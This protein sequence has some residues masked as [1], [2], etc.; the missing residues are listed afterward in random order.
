[1]R[2]LSEYLEVLVSLIAISVPFAV[3][4][5]FLSLTSNFDPKR[6]RQNAN[7]AALTVFITGVVAIYVGE[8][9]FHL[10][11]IGIPSFEVAGGLLI[12]LTGLAMVRDGPGTTKGEAS[13]H[14]VGVVPIGIPLLCGP[15]LISTI[16]IQSHEFESQIDNLILSG[17]VLILAFVAWLCLVG[18]DRISRFLGET[19]IDILTR[20]FGLILSAL[21]VEFIVAGLAGLFPKIL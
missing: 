7:S 11:S 6:R 1:M 9:L 21:A 14:D 20:I 18:A 2:E 16:L 12:L 13:D 10:F 3:T 17:C 4:P 8:R 5:V 15:G 19:G